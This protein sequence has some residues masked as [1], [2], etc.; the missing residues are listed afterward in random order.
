MSYAES[1][2]LADVW[3]CTKHGQVHEGKL[4]DFNEDHRC[5][6]HP[7]FAHLGRTDEQGKRI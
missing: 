2:H 1:K 6:V 5:Y 4:T 7:V 3:Y